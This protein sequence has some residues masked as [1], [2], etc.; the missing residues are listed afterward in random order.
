MF[1]ALSQAAHM[2]RTGI[3]AVDGGRG[4]GS[5]GIVGNEDGMMSVHRCVPVKSI[6]DDV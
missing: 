1:G 5:G 6:I 3:Y 4:R 2:F